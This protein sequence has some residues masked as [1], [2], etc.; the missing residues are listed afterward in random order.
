MLDASLILFGLLQWF[1]EL[2]GE[3]A[4][5][6]G[7]SDLELARQYYHRVQS[8]GIEADA[9]PPP[10]CQLMVLYLIRRNYQSVSIICHSFSHDEEETADFTRTLFL[11][12]LDK[13]RQAPLQTSFRTWLSTL[14]RNQ[15]IDKGRRQKLF[16]HYQ[17]HVKQRFSPGE[18]TQVDKKL[19]H[20]HL[21]QALQHIL[22]Q[23]EFALYN[24]RFRMG[25]KPR[26]IAEEYD[27]EVEEVYR[28][29][30]RIRQKIKRNLPNFYVRD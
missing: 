9:P 19:D 8:A 6:S 2:P 11:T 13:L 22:S 17:G 27:E 20:H 30:A 29:I 14:I 23:E 10:D 7:L 12:L 21:Q 16:D 24:L 26:E 18:E 3:P 5:V 1:E 25:Y 15:F 4:Y 28:R